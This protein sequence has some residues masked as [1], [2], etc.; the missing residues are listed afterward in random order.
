MEIT[1]HS[2]LPLNLLLLKASFFVQTSKSVAGN[3]ING[4]FSFNDAFPN[5]VI[6]TV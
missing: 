1:F 4:S 6:C 2:Q 5:V 3:G